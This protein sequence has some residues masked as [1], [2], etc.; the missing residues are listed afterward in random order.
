M[1]HD[2]G[3]T[4]IIV[5]VVLVLGLSIWRI[6]KVELQKLAP[7]TDQPAPGTDQPAP[8]ALP[9]SPE[10]IEYLIGRV[11]TEMERIHPVYCRITRGPTGACWAF[12][13]FKIYWTRSGT[14]LE[15]ETRPNWR[16]VLTQNSAL[17]RKIHSRWPAR[18]RMLD[19]C[20]DAVLITELQER[21]AAYNRIHS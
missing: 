11:T 13:D 4:A 12:P 1:A 18:Y 6:R 7:G 21:V 2:P 19:L 17:E 16:L 20:S 3:W 5:F 15:L 8:E 9:P 14:A 10:L